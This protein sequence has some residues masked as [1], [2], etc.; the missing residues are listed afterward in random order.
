MYIT[1]YFIGPVVRTWEGGLGISLGF[2]N[3]WKKIY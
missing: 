3:V 2:T 1:G